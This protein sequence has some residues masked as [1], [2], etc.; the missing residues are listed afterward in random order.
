MTRMI[1]HIIEPERLLL[2]WQARETKNRARYVVGQLIKRN[3][4]VT[5]HYSTDTEEFQSAVECGF[6]GYPAFPVSAGAVHTGRVLEA[7]TRRLP[8]RNRRDFSR[9]LELRGIPPD[10]QISDFALLGYTG[11]K[12]PNDGFELVHTFEHAQSDFELV[13][14]VAGFRHESLIPA[15]EIVEGESVEFVP[16]PDNQYDPEAIRIELR[17]TKIGYVDRGHNSLFHELLGRG[18]QVRGEIWRKNGSRE[19]PLIYIFM[20]IIWS[21]GNAILGAVDR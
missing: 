2:C 11:G 12:L 4:A 10:A 8:P 15:D 3:S 7:F 17:N 1:K 16:E 13:I 21:D 14:E 20:S 5:L 19:R 18:A 6:I 9:Y